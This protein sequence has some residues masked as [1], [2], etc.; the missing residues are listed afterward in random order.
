MKSYPLQETAVA[1]PHTCQCYL[2]LGV[3]LKLPVSVGLLSFDPFSLPNKFHRL[4]WFN[5]MTR[6]KTAEVWCY[7]FPPLASD[8]KISFLPPS[9]GWSPEIPAVIQKCPLWWVHWHHC[10]V[11][12][13]VQHTWNSKPA[14]Q[15]G[16]KLLFKSAI[17]FPTVRSLYW[18]VRLG[19]RRGVL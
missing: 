19:S 11:W 17:V 8:L 15:L 7:F 3:I 9:S 14:F 18:N 1:R 2:L 12:W 16:A 13:D 4:S 10:Q 6:G 5:A